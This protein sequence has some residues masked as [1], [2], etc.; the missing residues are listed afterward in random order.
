MR[1]PLRQPLA[2]IQFFT[3]EEQRVGSW[4]GSVVVAP[5]GRGSRE[6]LT[7]APFR[8]GDTISRGG[9]ESVF[10]FFPPPLFE[11]L[12]AI[13][14]ESETFDSFA[15]RDGGNLSVRSERDGLSPFFSFLRPAQQTGRRGLRL[16]K[17]PLRY[18]RKV[19][20]GMDGHERYS[21]TPLPFSPSPPQSPPR[22]PLPGDCL[23]R[24]RGNWGVPVFPPQVLRPA[25][26]Y[27]LET[28]KQS[29]GPYKFG[30]IEGD[31]YL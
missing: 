12:Y 18:P 31:V 10:P 19:D 24:S 20:Q 6:N 26:F 28:G 30:R 22:A 7:V 25:D 2:I 1:S 15:R 29:I 14:C 8:R 3:P 5:A 27:S 13:Y 4:R 11:I 23:S 17:L 16:D 21:A 9:G